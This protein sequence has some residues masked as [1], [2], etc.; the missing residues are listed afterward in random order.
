MKRESWGSRLGFIL[1]VSGSAVG[2]ANI[3]RFP[4]LVGENGGAV[5]VLIYLIFLV[6]LGFP[7]LLGEIS[8]GRTTGQ[9]PAKA[10]R[11]LGGKGWGAV[12]GMTIITGFIVSGFYS[13][14]AGWIVGYL[15]EAFRGNLTDFTTVGES[16]E[17]F[18]TWLQN[19]ALTLGSLILFLGM[20]VAILY[21]GVRKGIERTNKVLMPMLFLL[22]LVLLCWGLSLPRSGEAVKFLWMPDL[23]ALTPYAVLAALGQ[24]FF[25][26]SLGQGT[27][28][29][30][31]S[32]TP[33]SENL[34]FSC[35]PIVVMDT[36]VSF[37]AA[38][39]VFTILFSVGA[40][41]A[42]GPALLF[43]TLPVVFSQIPFGYMLAP[44]FFL[45][46]M[47]A[48]LTSEVSA[49]EPSVAY[50]M[51]KFGWSRKK[52]VTLVGVGAFLIGIPCALSHNLL[53][54]VRPFGH[55]IVDGLIYLGS[56]ILIPIGGLAAALLIGWR[57][58]GKKWMEEITQGAHGFIGRNPWFRPYLTFCVKYAAPLLIGIVLFQSIIS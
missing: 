45:L 11:M 26:L 51:D 23:K 44:L 20:S 40:E 19:P 24:A 33:K 32:Y 52:C 35:F 56:D 14:V 6:L 17:Y 53:A 36:V 42:G 49:M 25:T 29:T 8:V 39:I 13:A 27:M 18:E 21:F 41:G 10:F 22:L 28:V 9:S 34:V 4:H 50:L 57:W 1:A 46:V 2:L 37:V 43:H 30:Y 47:L 3:W 7:L 55:S 16:K 12:G 48:A 31:G 54:D 5:F 15:I 38:G 58:K